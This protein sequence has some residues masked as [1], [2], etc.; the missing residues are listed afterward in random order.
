MAA[1]L[2]TTQNIGQLVFKGGFSDGHWKRL[3]YAVSTG[4]IGAWHR[5]WPVFP[6]AAKNVRMSDGLPRPV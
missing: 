6:V 2:I 3:V 5:P 4:C 1:N